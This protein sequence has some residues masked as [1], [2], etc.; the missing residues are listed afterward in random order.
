[1]PVIKFDESLLEKLES[2]DEAQR[3]IAL[4][5]IRHQLN[6]TKALEQKLRER[7]V[8]KGLH[9]RMAVSTTVSTVPCVSIVASVHGSFGQDAVAR[10]LAEEIRKETMFCGCMPEEYKNVDY[11]RQILVRDSIWCG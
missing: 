5:A 1:M 4:R 11:E 6:A 10:G 8:E 9:E 3:A 2:E 7:L